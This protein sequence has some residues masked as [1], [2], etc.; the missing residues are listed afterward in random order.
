MKFRGRTP[1]RRSAISR[2]NDKVSFSLAYEHERKI[3]S[4]FDIAVVYF[5]IVILKESVHYHYK[6]G[7]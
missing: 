6:K 3:T 2:G 7:A 1:D 5:Q 4:C